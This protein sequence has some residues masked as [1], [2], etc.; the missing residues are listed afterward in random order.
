MPVTWEMKPETRLQRFWSKVERTSG[1][2]LWT[3][4]KS[5]DGYGEF[6]SK[7][8]VVRAHRFVYELT[9][10]AIPP[11]HLV[12]HHCDNPSCIRPEHLFLGLPRDNSLDMKLKGRAARGDRNGSRHFFRSPEWRQRFSENQKK[13]AVKGEL[14][15]TAKLTKE[16]VRQIRAAHD[17][18][19][20]K[21]AL[22]S[23]FGVHRSQVSRV[24][25]RQAW[26]HVV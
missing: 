26:R 2:W 3:G 19:E 5:A 10:E 21:R 11:G 8:K 17:R 15:N 18:G 6:T 1:C 4:R 22:A 24:M 7:G 16:S 12:C 25:L 23:A 13:V 9:K 14:V 20:S